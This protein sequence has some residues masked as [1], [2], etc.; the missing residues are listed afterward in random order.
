M[1]EL[2]FLRV[3]NSV[4]TAIRDKHTFVLP[5]AGYWDSDIGQTVYSANSSESKGKFSPFF[6]KIIDGK[7]YIDNNLCSDAYQRVCSNVPL[8]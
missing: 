4:M 6:I 8:S 1:S 7:I 5:S 2:E 3:I